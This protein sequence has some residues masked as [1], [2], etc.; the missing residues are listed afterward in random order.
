MMLEPQMKQARDWCSMKECSWC[1]VF[2]AAAIGVTVA[3]VAI[4]T[5]LTKYG[6]QYKTEQFAPNDEIEIAAVT[7]RVRYFGTVVQVI[8]FAMSIPAALVY[9]KREREL[10]A[11]EQE[12]S[13]EKIEAEKL[14]QLAEENHALLDA[15]NDMI[16]SLTC[17][18]A[19]TKLLQTPPGESIQFQQAEVGMLLPP[20]SE[21]VNR[22]LLVKVVVNKI[23][24]GREPRSDVQRAIRRHFAQ[25]MLHL[26]EISQFP[27]HDYRTFPDLRVFRLRLVVF[28]DF[29]SNFLKDLSNKY[30]I[31]PQHMIALMLS[32]FISIP[33][34]TSS[35][36]G[37]SMRSNH[38]LIE[39]SS[40]SRRR[41]RGHIPGL[42][43]E[44]TTTQ[45]E[46]TMAHEIWEFLCRMSL[47]QLLDDIQQR[48]TK[49][50]VDLD[51]DSPTHDDAV[52]RLQSQKL[53]GLLSRKGTKHDSP[54]SVRK[55]QSQHQN[56]S[57]PSYRKMS[58]NQPKPKPSPSP[59]RKLSHHAATVRTGT[60]C[61]STS[62]HAPYYSHPTLVLHDDTDNTP[63]HTP[64]HS[65]EDQV[66]SLEVSQEG[67]ERQLAGSQPD[68]DHPPSPNSPW[69]NLH[70]SHLSHSSVV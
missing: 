70:S 21:H 46:K 3:M 20:T 45:A 50:Q 37:G 47:T 51:V 55:H 59:R 32:H 23:V 57:P 35:V 28:T 7:V 22:N 2:V 14:N 65:S 4:V 12:A 27:I 49:P 31:S 5:P 30:G 19:I 33:D 38:S 9:L 34:D 29:F 41:D 64:V 60:P 8:V 13:R 24:T 18:R 42:P 69:F 15:T 39:P 68:A 67:P 56:G 10:W 6:Y 17:F 58:Q 66:L 40:P 48:Q 53:Q 25:V 62:N 11:D 26:A 16:N 54:A 1:T 63:S 52:H 36:A 43:D 61:S 44:S